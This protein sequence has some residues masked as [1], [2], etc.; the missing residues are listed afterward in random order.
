M[1][2]WSE[3][4]IVTGAMF[5][6]D[7][8]QVLVFRD[9]HQEL[10]M[11]HHAT[12]AIRRWNQD[13]AGMMAAAVAYYVA[14]SAL[15]TLLLVAAGLGLFLK[16]TNSGHEAHEYILTMVS[17][18]ANP[19]LAK[20]IDRLLMDV[21]EL[22]IYGGPLGALT[23]LFAALAMFAQLDR[24]FDQIYRV[25]LPRQTNMLASPWSLVQYRFRAFAMILGLGLVVVSIFCA[26]I[27][28]S[29][30]QSQAIHHL[31][32]VAR[33]TWLV[34]TMLET[35]VNALVFAAVYRFVPKV[36]VRWRHALAGGLVAAMIWELGRQVLG[37]FFIGQR[38]TSA[39]GLIGALTGMMLWG[40]YGIAVLFAGAEYAQV[41]AE[42]AG[43][44]SSRA[45]CRGSAQPPPPMD[46]CL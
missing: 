22:A 33:V 18:Q 28:F 11:W 35:S 42:E 2:I 37:S 43:R 44:E 29:W 34:E 38:Y 6:S 25:E 9:R 1:D 40:Y 31:P 46:A 36:P 7:S 5:H 23:L 41:L 21:E 19:E 20:S 14:L 17:D 15:P 8:L 16:W 30:S 12:A 39:Y 4:H 3:L 10:P 26:G 32:A 45:S 13:N 27:A 24:A